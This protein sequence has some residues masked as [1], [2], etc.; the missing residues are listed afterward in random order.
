MFSRLFGRKDDA[1]A[2]V[3]AIPAKPAAVH[4]GMRMKA[5]RRSAAQAV[6]SGSLPAESF[7]RTGK[8]ADGAPPAGPQREAWIN[9]AID[10][11]LGLPILS[12]VYVLDHHFLTALSEH[13]EEDVDLDELARHPDGFCMA[14]ERMATAIAARHAWYAATGD[15]LEERIA[16]ET[17]ILWNGTREDALA[18]FEITPPARVDA[19][20]AADMGLREWIVDM[21][22][23]EAVAIAGGLVPPADV[24]R[25]ACRSQLPVVHVRRPDGR[26][27][28][29]TFPGYHPDL[30]DP[31]RHDE[32]AAHLASLSRQ[33]VLNRFTELPGFDVAA[34]AAYGRDEWETLVR[35]ALLVEEVRNL[36]GLSMLI[37][38]DEEVELE[39]VQLLPDSEGMGFS[40]ILHVFGDRVCRITATGDGDMVADEWTEGATREDLDALDTYIAATG[41]PRDDGETPDS[42]AMRLLDIVTVHAMVAEYRREAEAAVL[43]G[44][45]GPG[46]ETLHAEPIPEGWTREAVTEA[47]LARAPHAVPLDRLDDLSAAELWS[48]LR[49]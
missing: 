32:R 25:I 46:G 23:G 45:E 40:A 28:P 41:E 33:I 21:L 11:T 48:S 38:D 34:G 12:S 31:R 10:R 8:D 1:P 20:P 43:F 26:P 16:V 17:D 49:P 44:I 3:A 9:D 47:Y 2:P 30:H 27:T 7:R 15:R 36:S 42:L 35:R 6:A 22:R 37:G 4:D 13:V 14:F 18:R 5:F 19:M 24:A 39:D 29:I